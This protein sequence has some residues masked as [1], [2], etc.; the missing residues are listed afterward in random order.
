MVDAK[1]A[2]SNLLFT[3]LA[4]WNEILQGTSIVNLDEYKVSIANTK[5]PPK[6]KKEQAKSTPV[7]ALRKIGGVHGK[8]K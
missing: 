4:N 5:K 3:T 8:G 6:V 1:G 2:D 7:K